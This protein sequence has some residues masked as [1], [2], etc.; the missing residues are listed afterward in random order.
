MAALQG[1]KRRIRSVTGTRQITKAMQMVSASKLRRAQW[2]AV[3]PQAYSQ[4]ARELLARLSTS[5]SA[6]LHP[7]MKRRPVRRALTILVAGDRGMAGAY[8]SN[9]IRAMV[10]HSRELGVPQSAI[11]IGRRAATHVARANDVTQLASYDVD[12]GDANTTVVQPALE[13][14]IGLFMSGEVDAVH[15]IYT[16]FDSTIK[17]EVVT[18][19]LLPVEPPEGE[20]T[21]ADVEFEPDADALLSYAVRRVLEAQL[22][23]AVLD[24]RASEHASRMIAM[25]NA[26]DNASDLIGDL[27]LAFNNARQAGITQELAEISGGAEAINE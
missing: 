5:P 25:M 7:L 2:A 9:I 27:T 6:A 22:M 10:R 23:Q 8:N 15:V 3:G 21:G 24:A 17:Q 12:G 13:E 16:R 1:I 11:S 20:T 4:A 18:T 26:T 19:K 14:A